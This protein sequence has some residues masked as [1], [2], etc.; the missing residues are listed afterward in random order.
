LTKRYWAYDTD[1]P[2]TDY[3]AAGTV[4][5]DT[6]MQQ[7]EMTYD[8]ASNL[9]Q[10]T[11]RERFHDANGTN[12]YGELRDPS[13]EPRARVSQVALYPCVCG[14]R[15]AVADYGTN[16]G[17]SFTRPTTIPARSETVLVT[18]FDYNDRGETEKISDAMGTITHQTFDDAGRLTKRLE[19]YVS[20][21]SGADQ[22]RETQCAYHA[23]GRLKTLTAK[24]STTGDQLTKYVYGTTLANSDVAS[25]ELLRAIIYPDSDDTDSP[26]GNGADGVYDRVEL[27]YNRLGEAKEKKD[28]LATVHTHE[29][30]KLGR[31]TQDRVTALGSGVDNALKRISRSY[32]VRGML[33][34]ITSYDN[35]TV[36]Q[37]TVLN[38][39]QFEYNTFGQLSTEYQ[40]HG[41]AVN[42]STSPKVQYAYANGSANHFRPT[43]M[44]YPNGQSLT[45]DYG[46][47][48]GSDDVLSRVAALKQGTTSLAA[49]T[50][51]GLS[52]VL[53]ASYGQPQLELTYIKQAGE[54]NGDAGDQYTGLDRFGRVVDQRWLKGANAVERVKYGFNRAHNRPWR[55][56]VVASAGQDEYYTYDGLYQLTNLDRGDLNT[57]KTA[58]DGTPAR[59]EDFSLDSSGNWTAYVIKTSGSTDLNQTREHNKANET[60]KIDGATTYL[61]YDAVGNMIKTPKPSAW[62]QAFDLKYDAWNRL[63]KVEDGAATVAVYKY[64]G[65]NRRGVKETYAGGSLDKT[66]HYYYSDRWQVLEERVDTSSSP[67]RQYVWGL[68]HL[69]DLVLRDWDSD[70][71]GTVDDR[72]YAVGDVFSVTGTVDTSGN[73]QERYGYEAYGAMRVMNA[74]FQ[75][76]SSTSATSQVS[77]AGYVADW[78]T[79]F[80]QVRN[81]FL[82][83]KLG[84]WT[85][86]DPL[87]YLG[88]TSLYA[89]V[90]NNPISAIDPGGL[91]NTGFRCLCEK[92]EYP[93]GMGLRSLYWE[94]QNKCYNRQCLINACE[95]RIE[96]LLHAK[97]PEPLEVG[98]CILCCAALQL[99]GVPFH[100]CLVACAGV[101][102]V[103]AAL[104]IK[105]CMKD[106]AREKALCEVDMWYC[107]QQL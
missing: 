14:L 3:S 70:G 95:R 46:S 92:R 61:G 71:N 38:E 36:G 7:V 73:V 17:S 37:G 40:E 5:G 106:E 2:D 4:S 103:K 52:Q 58:I 100:L 44:T 84:R 104:R 57:G 89:Y 10:Q 21:G 53:K 99:A 55:E 8:T 79:G 77:Y 81:R 50:Y 22:N 65:V 85:T 75:T 51:L 30:D 91:A 41:G 69:D 27:K 98:V 78:E 19:N 105:R 28:Q 20:G 102:G 82:H 35:S 76:S 29:Y 67:E 24:N 23:N 31:L 97:K 83:P 32:E 11:A 45:F 90:L 66:R 13:T 18:S 47:S 25:N 72:R 16:G 49:Y 87:L 42:T 48:G 15:K 56:N 60:T 64:D 94:D 33:Q 39:V 6:V 68:R 74:S 34:K 59:E 62:N 96:C 93:E 1:E 107:R 63:V 12:G 80:Y 26:L 43:T 101:E 86:R 9:I 88:G 54:S